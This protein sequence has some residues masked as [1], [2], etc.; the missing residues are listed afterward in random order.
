LLVHCCFDR[1]VL[2]LFC[3]DGVICSVILL[4]LTCS[5]FLE[6]VGVVDFVPVDSNLMQFFWKRCWSEALL[7]CWYW[8]WNLEKVLIDLVGLTHCGQH[9]FT[10]VIDLL[11]IC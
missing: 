9:L 2:F 7:F 4:L 11:L 8:Y 5:L 10:A 1:A 6:I 3:G